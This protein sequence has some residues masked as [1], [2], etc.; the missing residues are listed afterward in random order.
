MTMLPNRPGRLNSHVKRACLPG[1]IF[2]LLAF[3]SPLSILRLQGINLTLFDLLAVM[4]LS[5]YLLRGGRYLLLGWVAIAYVFILALMLSAFRSPD[6]LAA[7][8]HIA[9]WLFIFVIVV[10]LIYSAVRTDDSRKPIIAGFILATGIIV[11]YGVYEVLFSQQRNR[12]TSIYSSPQTLGFQIAV[13]FPFLLVA[14]RSIWEEVSPAILK[15]LLF[16][17]VAGLIGAM[18]WL[19]FYTLSR[20]GMLA[21]LL[22]MLSFIALDVIAIKNPREFWKR[23]LVGSVLAT[24]LVGAT[25][26]ITRDTQFV[27]RVLD[28]IARTIDLESPEVTDR[29][30][31][32]REALTQIDESYYLVGVGPDNYQNIS[33]FQQ[34]PHNVFLL[35]LTEGGVVALLAFIALLAYFFLKTI[36]PLVIYRR[37]PSQ[38]RTFL[39]GTAAS[40][41]AY[42]V[43]AMFNTQSLDRLY[44]FIFAAGLASAANVR[45]YHRTARE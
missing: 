10:P 17:L 24:I 6:Q 15:L 19:L 31:V 37:L 23:L 4:A 21:T 22:G 18:F 28:R 11:A 9:Q 8:S 43:I 36:P 13:L 1:W 44:W 26:Q 16:P 33:R 27:E 42:T 12:Y 20:T 38:S 25:V 29:T 2:L 41:I 35:F 40:M 34:R 39:A 32:W 30:S 7:L 3:V 5:I 14:L 45:A